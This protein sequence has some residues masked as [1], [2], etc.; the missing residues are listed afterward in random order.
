MKSIRL[1]HDIRFPLSTF[2]FATFSISILFTIAALSAHSPAQD[3]PTSSPES[4]GLDARRLERV[5]QVLQRRI[6]DGKMV[7]G[8]WLVARRGRVVA[9]DAL[10]HADVEADKPMK[11]DTL[12]RIYSMT[13]PITSVGVMMLYEEG[14][15]Q[16]SDPVSKYIPKLA[17][18]EVFVD[19]G[20]QDGKREKP[21]RAVTIADLLSHRGGLT[22]GLFGNSPVDKLYQKTNVLDNNLEELID[23]LSGLPLV[24]HPGEKWQY[25]VSTDV[26]GRLVEVLSKK[27]LREFF[28]ERIFEPLG[29]SDTD[30]Y[31]P[32]E[33]LDRFPVNYRWNW[34]GERRIADHPS[35]SR[36]REIPT[37]LSGGGGLVSSTADYYRFCQMLLN[38][39]QFNGKRLLGAKTIEI[40]TM[41][42][43]D[44]TAIP[45][46][47]VTVG[48]GAG[49][50][51]GFRV[52]T[53]ASQNERLVSPGTYGWGGMASTA[54]F[55][56]PQEEL[57]GIAMSQKFPTDMRIRD[58]F[59][60]AVYQAI[61]ELA[62]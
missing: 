19:D 62:K 56:D 11:T 47:G 31:V 53:D 29:M 30:F 35:Q 32:K 13:K 61:T 18:V 51:L 49:F 50:G 57:I 38:G 2:R 55:I 34:S 40:M 43:L 8:V 60:T 58:E 4:V 26:L 16:L 37:F 46:L 42:H 59:Q 17:D 7:G 14:H 10:G 9:F 23:D 54:F 21:K 52:V 27:T 41:D 3:L 20:T 28:K 15:F 1:L 36:Y 12:F 33:K 45:K 22:Y 5:Q 39:G 24:S 6:D 44:N 48:G 25:S